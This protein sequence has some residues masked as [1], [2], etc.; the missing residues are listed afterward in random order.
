MVA[1]ERTFQKILPGRSEPQEKNFARSESEYVTPRRF[2]RRR[3]LPR[4]GTTF[5]AP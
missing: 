1:L 2:R 3:L 4:S 5:E